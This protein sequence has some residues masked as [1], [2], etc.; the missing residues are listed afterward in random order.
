MM[1]TKYEKLFESVELRSGIKLDSR[2]AMAPMVVEGSTYD[3]HVGLDDIKYFKRRSN[4]ASMLITGA[5][6]VS[7]NTNAFGYGL[8]NCDDTYT[9]GMKELS[10][11]MKENEAKAIMQLFHPG[12]E[13]KYSFRDTGKVY[14]PSSIKFSF[15]DYPTTE[16]TNGEIESIIH[17]FGKAT[18][19]A[20][21]A[22]F[23]GIEIHGAN[24]YLI[25]QFFSD[26]SNKRSDKWGGSLEKRAAFP[27]A[28]IDEVKKIVDNYAKKPFI[29]GYRISPEEIHEN[30]VGY[31][32]EDA[33]Y[34]I[35]QISKKKI[36]Y[37]HISLWGPKAYKTTPHSEMYEDEPIAKIVKDNLDDQTK[38]VIVGDVTSP[39]N[40]LE[41]IKYADIIA[42]GTSS[43]L[44]PEFMVKIKDGK[45]DTISFDVSSRI[46]E[47]ELPSKFYLQKRAI[48]GNN[49]VPESTKNA[50]KEPTE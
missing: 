2:F 29:I 26:F 38:L 33:L 39:D 37:I 40:A 32:F 45:E 24:H 19:R 12:R 1:K 30:A 43:L 50:I 11:A 20:I 18:L 36:D 44:D 23:D 28:I 10:S 4:T 14:A 5:T 34:L 48:I 16:L 17:D 7:S 3:G 46:Q 47:L 9:E 6:S 13:A 27:L 8:V 15:L 49:V 42:M 41:A 22:G 21:E 35:R 25:Q 31:T